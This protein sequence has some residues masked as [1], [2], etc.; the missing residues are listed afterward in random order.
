MTEALIITTIIE[1]RPAKPS[2]LALGFQ[3]KM[4]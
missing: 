4:E 1:L 3:A 2:P